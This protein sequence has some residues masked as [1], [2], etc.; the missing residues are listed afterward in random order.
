[1][2][3]S[4]CLWFMVTFL[5]AANT[6]LQD[7]YATYQEVVQKIKD[8]S[9]GTFDDKKL[10]DSC[11]EGMVKSVDKNG[12][13]LNDEEYET[14]YV[15]A[16]PVAGIG[17]IL[18][19]K[20]N[21]FYVKS[22]IDYS[23]AQKAHLQEGDEIIQIENTLVRD[24]NMDEVIALLRGAPNTK[25]KVI[26]MKKNSSR[27]TEFA[28]MRKAVNVDMV[29]SLMYDGNIAYIKISS[30]VNDA[31]HEMLDD[32]KYLYDTQH[33]KLNGM[34]LDLRG[35]PG[36]MFMNGI[37]ITSF[38]LES[39]RVILNVKS[40]H[41]EDKKQYRNSPQDF[42][43]LEYM[44]KVEAL[45]FFKTIPLVV[46]IDGDSAGSS[47]IIA[48]VLQEYGR[49]T[50]IGVPSFGK[51]TF[52]TLFPLSTNSSAIK[53]ATARWT[54]PK[55]KSVW[56]NGVIPNIEVHHEYE[57]QDRALSEALKIIQKK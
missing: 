8:E 43:G 23:S 28:L 1:M 20:R 39:D 16:K 25:V 10:L 55:G 7:P 27:P 45:P 54:T 14:L 36:G 30:Y 18:A 34:V 9:I 32:I 52:A 26:V 31:I 19:Q 5:C 33:K 11:L 46:L 51:D 47:E 12:R 17:V 49:A 6:S 4:I 53:V 57:D 21:R 38:F 29:T 44:S 15:N 48:S 40:R 2:K 42:E 35:N 37:A 13:Y 56:P 41:K 22:I 24:L 3:Y 50:I